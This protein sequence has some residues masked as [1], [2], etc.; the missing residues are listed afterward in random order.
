MSIDIRPSQV[1]L[2]KMKALKKK[3][4]NIPADIKN[5]ERNLIDNPYLGTDLGKG[6]RKVRMKITDKGKGK[7]GGA[8]II[9]HS[10][11]FSVE[12]G[13]ITLLTIYDKSEQENISD[14]ELRELL[15]DVNLGKGLAV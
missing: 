12:D 1:F 8:R 11:I 7:S 5:L 6:L 4:H 2:R 3:Y 9:L 13:H 10:A 15:N 14:A